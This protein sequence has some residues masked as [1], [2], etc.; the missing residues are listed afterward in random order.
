MPTTVSAT[1]AQARRQRLRDKPKA[2][3]RLAA[4]FRKAS[5]RGEFPDLG[6]GQYFALADM[7]CEAA[8]E[9]RD[10]DL[11]KFIDDC[12]GN[13][14]GSGFEL[15]EQAMEAKLAASPFI[16]LIMQLL[17]VLLPLLIGCL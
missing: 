9:A 4:E 1:Q 3:V 14:N 7:I 17:P 8:Q 6:F 16:D 10:A 15:F 13:G 2:R 12:C 11:D 5:R